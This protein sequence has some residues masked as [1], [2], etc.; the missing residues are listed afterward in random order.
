M[1]VAKLYLQILS[2]SGSA[3]ANALPVFSVDQELDVLVDAMKTLSAFFPLAGE[4]QCLFSA[5]LSDNSYY[6]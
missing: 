6:R 1:T 2:L 5:V 4:L 3:V